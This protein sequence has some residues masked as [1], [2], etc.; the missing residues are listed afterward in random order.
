MFL[1]FNKKKYLS[2]LGTGAVSLAVSAVLQ[3]SDTVIGGNLIGPEAVS[4][5]SLITSLYAVVMF[6][7]YLVTDGIC[8]RYSEAVGR[9]DSVRAARIFSE[10]FY[11]SVFQGALLFALTCLCRDAYLSIYGVSENIQRLSRD[12]LHFYRYVFA[13]TPIYEYLSEMI[14][15]EGDSSACIL[16]C[17]TT[18]LCNIAVSLLMVKHAGIAGLGIGSLVGMILS[19]L[20]LCTHFFKKNNGLRFVCFFSMLDMIDSAKYSALDASSY[21]FSALSVIFINSTVIRTLG[22][23]MLPLAA[24]TRKGYHHYLL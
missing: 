4:A 19:I 2:L 9:F 22:E 10:G 12:Y 18:L 16:S 13:L 17:G 5:I 20:L 24:C 23:E 3:V 8:I 15:T 6:F 1:T 7:S 14:Y 11:A 21:L